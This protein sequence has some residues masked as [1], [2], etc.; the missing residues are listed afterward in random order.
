MKNFDLSIIGNGVIATF[1]AIKIKKQ[2]PKLKIAL[3]GNINRLN[4]ASI[5]AGAMA[6][7][8]AEIENGPDKN[9][10]E[11]R[12]LEIGLK[13]REG[14]K[15]FFNEFNLNK[16]IVICNDTIVFLKS[17]ASDFE[18]SNFDSMERAARSDNVWELV[19]SRLTKETFL[20]PNVSVEK[21]IKLLG[22][23]SICTV[24]LFNEL[25]LLLK[26]LNIYN[27]FQDVIKV[28]ENHKHI[29][30]EL[31]NK[32]VLSS[33]R[34]VVA[35][36]AMSSS[37]FSPKYKILPML[38]GV[39]TA[40]IINMR[41]QLPAAYN[42]YVIR[43][44]NRG[45]AQ[46]GL[47]TVPRNDGTLYLGAG[48]YIARPGKCF[49]RLETIK[50]LFSMFENEMVGKK[51]S[52]QL[53]GSL[54]LGS[55]PRSF[56]GFPMIGAHSKDDRVYFATGTNRVGLTW[57]P[58]IAEDI[59]DW[60]SGKN[61]SNIFNGWNPDR[62]PISFGTEKYCIDYF[63]NSR[64]SAAFEHGMLNP[65]NK[66]ECNIKNSEFILIAKDFIKKIKKK[67]KTKKDMYIN[68]DNWN[69]LL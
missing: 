51:I 14:W 65:K 69:A 54:S 56:D 36:G 21:A 62:D 44:V 15:K 3:I 10:N 58:R 31:N 8:Y 28:N 17:S 34:I 64:I 49:H 20:S 66:K 22:E 26:K 45:G 48:N 33:K 23:F 1:A 2:F 4:S 43:T 25:D 38:Q 29:S 5:A 39:G 7:V 37:I 19:N 13:G 6:N 52:Y 46:C 35:A 40:I 63:R 11:A 57:A 24:S 68:P 41:S 9:I 30:I 55:R 42:K 32:N 27:I 67:Y 53:L 18:R 50:Y 12:Y 16:K 59:L 61:Q 47:H 60:M